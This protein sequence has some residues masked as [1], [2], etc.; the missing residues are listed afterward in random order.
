MDFIGTMEYDTLSS[1]TENFLKSLLSNID[2]VSAWD[3][4]GKTGWG[5]EGEW[6]CDKIG[7]RQFLGQ[8]SKSH[9]AQH[10]SSQLEKYY[11]PALERFVEMHWSDDFNNPYFEF[12]EIKLFPD[13]EEDEF[14]DAE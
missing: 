4:A 13:G 11:T 5:I 6:S 3:R 7:T 12:E 9:H 1:E 10:A 14:S 2:G 8:R